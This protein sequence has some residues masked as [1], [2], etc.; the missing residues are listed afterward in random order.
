MRTK[1]PGR[2]D[3]D[4]LS[5]DKITLAVHNDFYREP[6]F[7]KNMLSLAIASGL[8]F[9]LL[10][11]IIQQKN[12]QAI[13]SKQVVEEQN[14]AMH[15]YQVQTAQSQLNAHFVKNL[16]G[17]IQSNINLDNKEEANKRLIQLSEIMSRFLNSSVSADPKKIFAGDLEINLAKEIELLRYYIELEQS[18]NP[19]SFDFIIDIDP[20]IDLKN[21][22][23][24]PMILQP[25]VENAIKH[26]LGKIRG[27]RHGHLTIQFNKTNDDALEC[28]IKDNG[29]GFDKN[30]DAVSI[31]DHR[32]HGGRLVRERAELLKKFGHDIKIETESEIN[33]GTQITIKF[34][35]YDD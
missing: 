18:L 17:S 24:V 12:R 2:E 10:L 3:E 20:R 5:V 31:N 29:N 23:T 1:H 34:S 19:G 30:I 4:Y 9:L 27:V 8:F 6:Y 28:I 15:Y 32:S 22:Y 11:Y 16:L 14:R 35:T 26:G 21:T 25:F 13:K 33:I 7:Y